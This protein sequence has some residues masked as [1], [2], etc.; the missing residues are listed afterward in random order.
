MAAPTVEHHPDPGD[1]GGPARRPRGRPR[2]VQG[3]LAARE[4]GG[5]R[6]ARLRAGAEQHLLQRRRRRDPR[7]PRR[8]VG[9]VRLRRHRPGLRRL[10]RPAR[11][12]LVRR[13]VHRRDHPLGR[14]LRPPRGRQRLPDP[15]G[16]DQLHLPGQ[17]PLAPG[18]DVPRARRRRPDRRDPVADPARR[19]RALGE[20]PP[21]EPAAGR[22]D[23]D[24]AAPHD[25]ARRQRP[26]RP[27]PRRGPAAGR[28]RR[29]RPPRP[30]RHRRRSRAWPWADYDT[31][32]NAA[33]WTA[34]DAAEDER[35]GAWAA[36]ATGARRCSPTSP[37]STGSPWC[38]T[39]PTTSSTAPAS[40]TR[41]DEPVA[42]LGRLR[43][44]QGGRR[45]RGR[46]RA[47]P[48]RAAHLVGDRRRRQ[49]RAHDG[50]ARRP[51]HLAERGRRPARPADLRRRAGPGHRAP[52]GHRR[53][54]RHLPRQQRRPG[55]DVGRRSPGR[56]SGSRAATPRT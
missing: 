30:H 25:R 17:R 36:N 24:G 38:T 18:Y 56:C 5:P 1:G 11:G 55:H 32:I 8:A 2:L 42:P 52:A 47:P 14:R 44:V 40:C 16:R 27:G 13:G 41:E 46:R 35:A 29:P 23:A 6:A 28:G 9:Q 15:R 33:A 26:A 54:V 50:L 3:E 49:L 19:R 34:V 43:P 22:R 7:H 12:R 39:P 51:G 31:I 20:G 53:G 4:D 45:A 48:L 37:A 10:G 21:P